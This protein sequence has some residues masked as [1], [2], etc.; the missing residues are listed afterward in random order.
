MAE[1]VTLKKRYAKVLRRM[2]ARDLRLMRQTSDT[3]SAVRGGG[4]VYSTLPDGFGVSP[5][6]GRYLISCGFLVSLRDDLFASIDGGGQVFALK[7]PLPAFNW[8][9]ERRRKK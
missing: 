8:P 3:I 4:Y 7:N 9:K 2:I 5:D 1:V 6:I